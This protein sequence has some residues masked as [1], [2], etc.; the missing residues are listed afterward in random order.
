M[1]MA[2]TAPAVVDEIAGARRSIRVQA[3]SFTSVP[4]LVALKAAHAPGAD[5]RSSSTRP[6]PGEQERVALIG[7]DLSQQCRRQ[8]WIDTR[9]AI[10]KV[11]P[12]DGETV[13]TG[14]FN[15]TAAL[16]KIRRTRR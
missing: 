4:I 6:R 15:F 13:I 16:A 11:M 14:S 7:G 5:A 1:R 10:A 2:R 3:Y 8:V 12:L 9:V